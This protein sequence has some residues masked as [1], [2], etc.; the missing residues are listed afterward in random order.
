MSA[1]LITAFDLGADPFFVYVLKAWIMK[2]KDGDWFGETVRGFAGWME[3]SF[4]IVTLFQA[5]ARPR[6]VAPPG[7]AAVRASLLPIGLYVFMMAFQVA[8]TR[9]VELRVMAFFVM[10]IPALIAF[11]AWLQWSAQFRGAPP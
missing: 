11:V 5:I 3:V 6:L 4:V 9:P 10:G 2:E 1:L 7:A 8:F